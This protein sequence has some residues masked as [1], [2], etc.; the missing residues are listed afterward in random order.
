MRPQPTLVN[1]N[2]VAPG[3][4]LCSWRNI[5]ITL[6]DLVVGVNAWFRHPAPLS[7]FESS[8]SFVD[9]ADA[10]G[11]VG[12]RRE[13][14]DGTGACRRLRLKTDADGKLCVQAK[15]AENLPIVSVCRKVENVGH[16]AFRHPEIDGISSHF[17]GIAV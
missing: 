15:S 10:M 14:H 5:P 1:V 3:R 2:E 17:A 9:V 6:I 8:S 11:I 13:L 16:G 12:D 7:R 4:P